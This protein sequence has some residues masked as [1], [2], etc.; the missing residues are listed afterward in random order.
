MKMMTYLM[1][2]VFL[3]MF[4]KFPAALTFYYFLQNVLGIL[5]QWFFT[6]FVIKEDKVR[7]E[8]ELAKK[9]PKKQGAFQQK[10]NEMMAQAEQQK[11]LQQNQKKK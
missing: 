1:P 11:K 3:F 6:T 9:T 2:A 8:M 7:A 10:M 4:N 5:Q